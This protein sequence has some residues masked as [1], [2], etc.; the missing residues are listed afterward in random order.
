VAGALARRM[1]LSFDKDT[2]ETTI[3]MIAREI[4]LEIEIMGG[5]L[6]MDGITRNQSFALDER[7][8]PAGE[9]LRAVLRK[10]NPD[11]KLIYVVQAGSGEREK[12]IIT[13]RQAA[14]KRKDPIPPEL[15]DVPS[16]K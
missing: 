15:A 11:G 5:D 16:P 6:E 3:E 8:K 2:L 10:A 4:D 14:A 1:S 9:V 13:T 7:D 12:L